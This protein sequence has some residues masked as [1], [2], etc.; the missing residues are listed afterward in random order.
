MRTAF[1]GGDHFSGGGEALSMGGQWVA[2][3]PSFAILL[4]WI[5]VAGCWPGGCSAGNPGT[6]NVQYEMSINMRK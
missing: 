1:L 6:A 2:A 4:V 3:L 5:A